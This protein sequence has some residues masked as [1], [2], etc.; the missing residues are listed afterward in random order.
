MFGNLGMG[1]LLVIFVIALVIFGPKKLPGLGKSLGKGIREFKKATDDLKANWDEHLREAERSIEAKE[2][3]KAVDH[4]EAHAHTEEHPHAEPQ[5]QAETGHE[6]VAP[7]PDPT[8]VE[9]AQTDPHSPTPVPHKP[10]E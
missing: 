9:A 5:A 3:Q 10:I 6:A 8:L 2:E 4:N 1:E 7:P